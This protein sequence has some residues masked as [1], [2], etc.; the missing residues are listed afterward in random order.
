[1]N[2]GVKSLATQMTP[3]QRAK[4]KSSEHNQVWQ[5]RRKS[6]LFLLNFPWN[7]HSADGK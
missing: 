2:K 5:N 3:V 6:K 7:F 4:S 1:M